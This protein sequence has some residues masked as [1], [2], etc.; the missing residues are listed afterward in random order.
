MSQYGISVDPEKTEAIQKKN[1]P[2]NKKELQRFLGKVVYLAKFMP[3]LCKET[4]TLRSLL[5]NKT[6]WVWANNQQKCFER[7]KD[8][9]Q[10]SL[11]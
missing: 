3:N 2:K 11:F 5:N 9:I 8:L 7:I 4:S 1:T 10:L 6:E